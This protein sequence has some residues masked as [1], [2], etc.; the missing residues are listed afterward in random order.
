MTIILTEAAIVTGLGGLAGLGFGTAV[1]L[2]QEKQ[3]VLARDAG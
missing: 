1:L 2:L 3:R